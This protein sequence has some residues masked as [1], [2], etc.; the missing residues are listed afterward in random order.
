MTPVKRDVVV[1]GGGFYGCFVAYQIARK[2]P[3]LSVL[4]LEKE[5]VLFARASGTNQ[6]QLHQGYM[7]SADVE[8]AAECASNAARFVA[9]FPGAVDRE[10]VSYFGVH[11]DSE[12]DP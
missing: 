1:I 7:Y 8:L 3:A 12:I 11:R 4:V 6:G 2:F 10:V 9:H 5:P